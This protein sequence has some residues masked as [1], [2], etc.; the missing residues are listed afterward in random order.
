MSQP[1]AMNGRSAA[2]VMDA[3]GLIA[4]RVGA[5]G[6]SAFE[7]PRMIIDQA[8]GVPSATAFMDHLPERGK[9]SAFIRPS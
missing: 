2:F 4:T 6:P 7:Q 3:T 5:A 9:P 1:P 8:T